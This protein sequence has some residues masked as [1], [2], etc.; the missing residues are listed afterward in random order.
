[1]ESDIFEKPITFQE[2]M[3]L[4]LEEDEIRAMQRIWVKIV[5][6]RAAKEVAKAKATTGVKD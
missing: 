5:S 2:L 6:A 4:D 3:M 1:M